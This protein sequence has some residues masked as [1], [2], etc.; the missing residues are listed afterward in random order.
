MNDD[1]DDP[2][3]EGLDVGFLSFPTRNWFVADRN[4]NRDVIW[5]YDDNRLRTSRIWMT[6]SSQAG[7]AKSVLPHVVPM[8]SFGETPTEYISPP[9]EH[10][11][12]PPET[13]TWKY[14]VSGF[15]Q[16]SKVSNASAS[17]LLRSKQRQR[18]SKWT[19]TLKMH[20]MKVC[21]KDR[22]CEPTSDSFASACKDLRCYYNSN[23]KFAQTDSASEVWTNSVATWQFKV[24]ALIMTYGTVPSDIFHA[25]DGTDA[26]V[27]KNL[28]LDTWVDEAPLGSYQLICAEQN[29]EHVVAMNGKKAFFCGCS[30]GSRC[31]NTRSHTLARQIRN[32][33]DPAF[34]LIA[35]SA[36][37]QS[38]LERFPPGDASHVNAPLNQ[39]D[40]YF[41]HA[42][43]DRR[44]QDIMVPRRGLTEYRVMDGVSFKIVHWKIDGRT[45]HGVLVG[46][47]DISLRAAVKHYLFKS[48]VTETKDLLHDKCPDIDITVADQR[49]IEHHP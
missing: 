43:L 40:F 12:A 28:N 39:P 7:H 23:V 6:L 8:C 10:G 20:R 13:D 22:T 34:P 19:Y 35:R 44:P 36:C 3:V 33:I 17:I 46:P 48:G 37:K 41:R 2:L 14:F 21:A 29:T 24:R 32:A 27:F 4:E 16:I 15:A 49:E 11:V 30:I 38:V 26:M 5:L 1:D 18:K 9:T 47:F 31:G 45:K 42:N 25:L